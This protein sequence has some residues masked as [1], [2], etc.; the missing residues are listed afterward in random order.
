MNLV[1]YSL[2]NCYLVLIIELLGMR[3]T[4]VTLCNKFYVVN[5][6]NSFFM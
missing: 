5:R 4:K 6:L 2:Q 1:L 3:A